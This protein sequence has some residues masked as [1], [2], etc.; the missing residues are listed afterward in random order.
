MYQ[1]LFVGT[2]ANIKDVS[3]PDW[4]PN[5]HMGYAFVSEL[6]Q[7][8]AEHNRL[9]PD[10]FIKI[11]EQDDELI[12][13]NAYN[14]KSNEDDQCKSKFLE[15]ELNCPFNSLSQSNDVCRLCLNEFQDNSNCIYLQ[16]CLS[17]S[18]TTVAQSIEALMQI[19]VNGQCL[20]IVNFFNTFRYH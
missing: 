12:M 14:E 2:P 19:E 15:D 10:V 4:A 11:E 17:D 16:S 5:Q 13:D 3:N 20:K 7:P 1:N 18:E 9:E 6:P 8:A